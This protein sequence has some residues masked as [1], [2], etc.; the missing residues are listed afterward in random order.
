MKEKRTSRGC[1]AP[2]F[3]DIPVPIKHKQKPDGTKTLVSFTTS[4]PALVQ[5]QGLMS[6]H[7][8]IARSLRPTNDLPR[9]FFFYVLA[10]CSCRLPRLRAIF[11]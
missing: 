4:R 7:T 5:M 3:I 2:R 10:T 9:T 11:K 6:F 1:L 8:Q